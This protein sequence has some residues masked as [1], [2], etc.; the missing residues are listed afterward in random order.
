MRL[1]GNKLIRRQATSLQTTFHHTNTH[2]NGTSLC[3]ADRR[4]RGLEII[5][6]MPSLFTLIV[7]PDISGWGFYSCTPRALLCF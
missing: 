7:W 6:Y 3:R 2:E 5:S 4:C 1:I